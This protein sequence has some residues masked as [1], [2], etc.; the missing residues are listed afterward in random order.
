MNPLSLFR[1]GSNGASTQPAAAAPQESLEDVLLDL[2]KWGKPKVGQ[3]GTDGTWQCS[4][5]VNVTPTGVR[6]EARSDFKQV[7]P[8]AAALM[9]RK[10]LLD[11][12]KAMG[13]AA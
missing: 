10:N 8:L 3:Y 1:G 7:T 9:C 5:D 6:F 12:V 11:A 13:G 2:A 4:I